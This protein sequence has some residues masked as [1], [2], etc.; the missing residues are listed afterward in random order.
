MTRKSKS[1]TSNLLFPLPGVKPTENPESKLRLPIL[2]PCPS[3]SSIQSRRRSTRRAT[4]PCVLSGAAAA[5]KKE[6]QS[7]RVSPHPRGLALW[8][9][10]TPVLASLRWLPVSPSFEVDHAFVLFHCSLIYGFS[11]CTLF[12]KRLSLL[13]LLLTVFPPLALTE[14]LHLSLDFLSVCNA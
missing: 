3:W 14:S 7:Q 12:M 8:E 10:I 6:L 4:R 11:I 9:D 5:R 1:K 13:S 2:R